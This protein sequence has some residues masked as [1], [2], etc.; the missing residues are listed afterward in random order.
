MN[1]IIR[2]LLDYARPSRESQEPEGGCDLASVVEDSTNLLAPQK[3]FR[4]VDVER[5]IA[6]DLP[7]VRGSRERLTQVLVNLLIN[8]ADAMGGTGLVRVGA[9]LVAP[10]KRP[11]GT[12][13]AR[14]VR[15]RVADSGPGIPVASLPQIFDP[16]F[17]TKEPGLGTGLGLAVCQGIIT[18]NGGTITA[19]NDPAGGAIFTIILPAVEGHD[20]PP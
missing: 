18:S 15:L 16:F 1:R 5:V 6:P 9:E 4:G 14:A 19:D 11:D 10:W 2:D 17:T 13:V 20:L 12:T 8:A 7:H 3:S